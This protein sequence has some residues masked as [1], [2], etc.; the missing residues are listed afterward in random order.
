[1]LSAIKRYLIQH[2]QATLADIA[3]H[4]NSPQA[5]V[6]GMLERWILKGKVRRIQANA[7]CG[8]SCRKCDPA[9]TEIYQWEESDG[10]ELDGQASPIP[11]DCDQ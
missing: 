9:L 10:T 1:M 7:A 2:R 5:A 3:L 8:S 4:L 11:P 6:R